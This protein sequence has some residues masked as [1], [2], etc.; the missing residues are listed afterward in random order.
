MNNQTE[1][2]NALVR[3][4]NRYSHEYYVLDNPTVSD[5]I[6][7]Q[8]Y[9][10]LAA[11]EKETGIILKGSPTQRVG[12]RILP[13]F[14]KVQHK[15]P[16]WSLDK[17]QSLEELE[18]FWKS[19]EKSWESFRETNPAA[20]R[21]TFVVME[22][23]DGLTLNTTYDTSGELSL[24]ATRGTGEIGEDVTEQS[25]TVVNLPQALDY[26]NRLAIHGEAI[27]TKKAFAE[28]NTTAKEPLK[29]LR[30][31]AAGAIR[32]LN[33]AESRKRKLSAMFYDITDTVEN[34]ET[35]SDKLFFME[36][37]GIPTVNYSVCSSF[38]N[39]V[40]E[41]RKIQE[42]RASLQYDIDGVV[43]KVNELDLAEFMG[44]TSKFPRFG[45]AYKFEAEETTTTLLEVEW[46]VGRTGRINPKA[47]LSP[48]D[49]GGV[50]VQRAT[51]NN[52]D[53][54]A[55]KGV[56]LGSEV[57]I[58]RS[59]DV[60][61]EITGTIEN[62]DQPD[63]TSPIEALENCPACNHP[64][65]QDGAFL[66]CENTLGCQPQLVK[67]VVHFCQREALN[68][69][70]FSI[71]T[72]EQFV[73]KG[74][75]DDMSDLYHLEMK[76]DDILSL[77]KF[78][79]KKYDNLLNSVESAKT[80]TLPRFIYGLGI[81]N[82]GLS[83]AKDLSAHFHTLDA[84]RQAS[85]EELLAV[86]DVGSIV[87]EHI[88][89]WFHS[90]NDALLERLLGIIQVEEVVEAEV[91]V[92]PFTDKTVVVT[93]TMNRFSRKEIKDYLESMGAKVSGSVS[94]KT[95]YLVH[96]E[97]AGSKLAKAQDLGVSIL[98]EAEFED[99][100]QLQ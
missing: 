63:N 2:M 89:H 43:I 37:Q 79:Q 96:G 40:E 98:T 27:M 12:D 18:S 70:G 67:A 25:R 16:L 32:N 5:A 82:V 49:L 80:T 23:L 47:I 50:T 59:N 21:P 68:I 53:D 52:M 14:K 17:A 65:I 33:I 15:S 31:G 34:F 83:T 66:Y 20:K 41:V 62:L 77:P 88:H 19:V 38:E 36:S 85:V 3:E 6:Y 48:V 30:N 81:K 90:N 4:L 51:L 11:L 22:K 35:L 99:L 94:K 8:K 75:I 9:D 57:I 29:N 64:L 71:K 95:D 7:D 54:I 97:N 55:K 56:R 1:Q 69:E 76:K 26:S 86:P 78:G 84:I 28:Y 10:L 91:T 42:A 87:A 46:A 73:E 61:P 45:I 24:S 13:G 60:I 93:G 72:A 58:R 39:I 74:I 44:Y 92:S 100:M